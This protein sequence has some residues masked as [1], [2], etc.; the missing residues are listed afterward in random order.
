MGTFLVRFPDG[1]REFRSTQDDPEEGD[2]VWHDGVRF[3]V[4]AV[5]ADKGRVIAVM[6]GPDSGDLA[7][8]RKSER[9]AL[10]LELTPVD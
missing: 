6:V 7:D 1:T 5:E 3:R 2:A 10:P 4:L 8:L 9:G